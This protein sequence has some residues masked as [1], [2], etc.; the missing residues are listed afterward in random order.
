MGPFVERANLMAWLE[1][2][3]LRLGPPAVKYANQFPEA[4]R[5]L[6]QFLQEFGT[7]LIQGFKK[8][9]SHGRALATRIE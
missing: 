9:R 2:M 8:P 7:E 4:D 1:E 3:V 5:K 6:I